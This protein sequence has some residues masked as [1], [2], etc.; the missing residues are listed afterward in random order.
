LAEIGF[1]AEDMQRLLA[2][3]TIYAPDMRDA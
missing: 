2:P 1:T 3:G